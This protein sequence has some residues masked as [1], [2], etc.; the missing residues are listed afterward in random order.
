MQET[1]VTLLAFILGVRA[2]NHLGLLAITAP[3]DPTHAGLPLRQATRC[4]HEGWVFC[5]Q[6]AV[7]CPSGVSCFRSGGGGILRHSMWAG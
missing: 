7:C 6:A 2:Q 4:V 1:W 5:P 3:A